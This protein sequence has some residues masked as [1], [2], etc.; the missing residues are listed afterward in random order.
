MKNNNHL[1]K[2]K[3]IQCKDVSTLAILEFVKGLTQKGASATWYD[4]EDDNTVRRVIPMVVPNCVLRKKLDN[5][6]RKGLLDGCGCGCRGDFRITPKGVARLL[7]LAAVQDK[8]TASFLKFLYDGFTLDP[9]SDRAHT[10]HLIWEIENSLDKGQVTALDRLLQAVD[11][12]RISIRSATALIRGTSRA[13]AYL[14]NWE[15]ALIRFSDVLATK[16]PTRRASLLIGL[17]H[18]VP[19]EET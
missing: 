8:N 10:R 12:H 1:T 7:V 16:Y 4:I 13:K 2:S 17:E 14:P 15:P 19:K 3:R 6:A 18:H 9:V 11:F 5:L